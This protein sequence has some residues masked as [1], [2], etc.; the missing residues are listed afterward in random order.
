MVNQG[1]RIIAYLM[2]SFWLC[3][4]CV[5]AHYRSSMAE[6]MLSPAYEGDT[7]SVYAYH[8]DH[9]GCPTVIQAQ[10]DE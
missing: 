9:P 3:V 2:G 10:L 8:C 7:F 4:P 6:G 1:R 5:E